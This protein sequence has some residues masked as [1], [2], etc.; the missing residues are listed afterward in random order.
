MLLLFG[1]CGLEGDLEGGLEGDTAMLF[2]PPKFAALPKL[3]LALFEFCFL[4]AETSGL[5]L[6]KLFNKL[7]TPLLLLLFDLTF[8]VIPNLLLNK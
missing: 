7:V 4:V 5:L 3:E 1:D 2:R 6:F 8:S